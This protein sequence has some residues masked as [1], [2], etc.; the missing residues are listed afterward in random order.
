MGMFIFDVQGDVE[1]TRALLEQG[2]DPNL[3]DHAGWTP[4]VCSLSSPLLSSSS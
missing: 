3:K 2:A 1:M 4:L